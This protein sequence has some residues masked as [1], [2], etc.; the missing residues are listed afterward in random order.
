MI[1]AKKIQLLAEEFLEGTSAFLVDVKVASGNVIRISLEN[2]D[3]TS[4]TDCVA[5][6]RHIEG[7]FDREEEDFSLD[8]GSPGLDQPLKVL[9]QYLKIVGKQIAVNPI[10]GKKLE[11]ELVSV[12]EDEGEFV[13]LVLKTREK[14]RIE[15]RK[16]T[17]WV[18]EE[19]QFQAGELEW[20]KVIISFK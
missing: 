4:I 18:D 19:H 9:R 15:G 2:D 1:N 6:S 17:E 20:T 11:G 5:L 16:A 3:R 8:V 10:E 12:E 14:K 13:G 7:S